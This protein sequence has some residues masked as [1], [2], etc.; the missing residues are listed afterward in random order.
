MSCTFQLEL[1]S[2]PITTILKTNLT[3]DLNN[4]IF[5]YKTSCFYAVNYRMLPTKFSRRPSALGNVAGHGCV[6]FAKL[7]I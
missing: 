3:I 6:S 4:A 1:S 5:F 2:V 7:Q